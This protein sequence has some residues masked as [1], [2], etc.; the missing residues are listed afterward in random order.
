[1]LANT[2]RTT[3]AEV[4][5]ALCMRSSLDERC[6]GQQTNGILGR[7]KGMMLEK[8]HEKEDVAHRVECRR[9]PETHRF[10]GDSMRTEEKFWGSHHII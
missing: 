6:E 4:W 7:V 5:G 3:V 2:E 10:I 8:W 9:A 1:V